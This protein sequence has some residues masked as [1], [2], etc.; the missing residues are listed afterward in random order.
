M[1]YQIL[2]R[3]MRNLFFVILLL[4]F[5]STSQEDRPQLAANTIFTEGTI[6]L[7]AHA[8][9]NY[10]RRLIQG[11]KT[12][13]FGRAGVGPSGIFF[14]SSGYGG[15][16][17]ATWLTGNQKNSHFEFCSGVLIGHDSYYNDAFFL[18]LLKVGYR[19]QKPQGG[20]LFR[21]NLGIVNV[22]IS[23]GYTF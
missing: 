10:E 7:L 1:F 19:F 2:E 22:G 12:S 8:T 6:G 4:P 3:N 23:F 14:G 21:A 16:L 18:P 11:A 15:L 17:G 5:L 9:L 20:F 13:L